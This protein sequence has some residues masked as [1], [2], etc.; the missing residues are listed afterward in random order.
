M[1]VNV[2]LMLTTDVGLLD[3]TLKTQSLEQGCYMW[4]KQHNP[5]LR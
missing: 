2:I 5:Y 3:M 4:L 1:D